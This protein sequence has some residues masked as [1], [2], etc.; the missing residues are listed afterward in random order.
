[1]TY[2]PLIPNP[3]KYTDTK[4]DSLPPK[5]S[6]IVLGDLIEAL[7]SA[8]PQEMDGRVHKGWSG[9]ILA[10]DEGEGR[11]ST[12]IYIPNVAPAGVYKK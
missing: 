1:V 2:I 4:L 8:T 11:I 9:R 7:T 12:L 5:M 6:H 10:V 3:L